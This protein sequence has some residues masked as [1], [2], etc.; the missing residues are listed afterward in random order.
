MHAVGSHAAALLVIVAQS[1]VGARILA[2]LRMDE[3]LSTH[4]RLLFGW[5]AGF[6]LTTTL[7]MGLAGTGFLRPA[8]VAVVFVG[9]LLASWPV[10]RDLARKIA[11]VLRTADRPT[12]LAIALGLA[13]LAAWAWPFWIETLLPN[14]DWDAALYH[15]PLAERYLDGSLWGRDPYFPAYSFPGAVQLLYAALMSLGLESAITPLN[16]QIT[17]LTLVATV[18]LARRIGDRRSPIW[19]SVAYSTT[20][21]LWQLGMDA[22]IDGFLTFAVVLAVYAVVRFAQEG[23][24]PH[25]ALAALSLG[26][27]IGCKYTAWPFVA[28]LGVVGIGFRLW[29]PRGTRGLGRLLAVAIVLLAVPNAAWYVANTVLHGDPFFP[30]LRGDYIESVSGERVHLARADEELEAARLED[31]DVRA[32]AQLFEATG[33]SHAPRHLLDLVDV[34]RNPE[35]YAVKPSHG[36]SPLLLLSL[37]LPFVLPVPPEKRRGALL[38]WGL[39]WGAYLLLGSQAPVLRYAMPAL[40]LLAAATG[41]LMTQVRWRAARIVVALA[42]LALFARDYQAQQRKLELMHAR[43]LLSA[44]PSPWNDASVRLD[45]L[46]QVGFNFTPP[47]AYMTNEIARRVADGR[48]PESCKIWMVG[49]GKG[50]LLPCRYA[51]D[52]SWFAHRLVG[53]LE[54][55]ELDPARLASSLRAQGFTHV[56]YNRAYYDWVLTDTDTSRSRVAFALTHLERFLD[57]YATLVVEA[58]GL[59]LYELRPVSARR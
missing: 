47:M 4:E 36:L 33:K 7:W 46:E 29:G 52:S 12:Q 37:A 45:W 40:P 54:A 50:R 56:L 25:L 28:V 39:G 34:L 18:V 6:A 41:V 42:A 59:R 8:P 11:V 14:A 31:P 35:R 15:L 21:I 57:A 26:V 49:E 44:E 2:C 5:A 38:V 13:A 20:P 55:A 48:M 51:P 22:R 32:R 58:G 53:E 3:A 19:A 43:Q 10:P 27:A 30:V 1:C 23:R 24:D 16:F 17:L 9:A